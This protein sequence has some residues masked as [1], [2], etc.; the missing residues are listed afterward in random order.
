ME[1]NDRDHDHRAIDPAKLSGLPIIPPRLAMDS[2]MRTKGWNTCRHSSHSTNDR[3][4]DVLKQVGND[5]SVLQITGWDDRIV[6][7]C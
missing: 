1:E 3:L 7:F 2:A 6:V 5:K 4:G